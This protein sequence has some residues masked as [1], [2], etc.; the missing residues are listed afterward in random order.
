MKNNTDKEMYRHIVNFIKI[1]PRT[2]KYP[3]ITNKQTQSYLLVQEYFKNH[4]KDINPNDYN[5]IFYNKYNSL[6]GQQWIEILLSTK[7]FLKYHKSIKIGYPYCNRKELFE[8]LRWE[9]FY[10]KSIDKQKIIVEAIEESFND[11]L[12]MN[13]KKLRIFLNEQDWS[14]YFYNLQN[15]MH[16]EIIKFLD[17]KN[18][19][20]NYNSYSN[21]LIKKLNQ[22]F[23]D[24][25][26]VEKFTTIIQKINFY[27]NILSK[28][29]AIIPENISE[30]NSKNETTK[31]AI[32]WNL[33]HSL[34]QLINTFNLILSKKEL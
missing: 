6:S 11:Q 16:Q 27:R 2:R 26:L 33:Y 7:N 17:W 25:T 32:A 18:K 31:E 34:T 23:N 10:W 9:L 3:K 29:T 28:A 19:S 8:K 13:L 22:E 12:K 1:H 24:L 14:N 5:N 30:W 4:K 20:L 21:L 15:V